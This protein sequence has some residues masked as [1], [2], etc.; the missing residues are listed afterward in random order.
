MQKS[1]KPKIPVLALE[2]SGE[3]EVKRV[4]RAPTVFISDV[5]TYARSWAALLRFGEETKNPLKL[6]KWVLGR[7]LW[8]NEWKEVV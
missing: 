4:P 7:S 1:G 3:E 8:V 6:A 5:K 2:A